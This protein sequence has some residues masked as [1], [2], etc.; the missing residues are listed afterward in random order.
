[1]KF[2]FRSRRSTLRILC[3]ADFNVQILWQV[4]CPTDLDVERAAVPA[5]PAPAP[6]RFTVLSPRSFGVKAGTPTRAPLPDSFLAW[7]SPKAF[8]P[9]WANDCVLNIV[10]T[11]LNNV[12][13]GPLFSN[14][15][16][17]ALKG[18]TG[19][20]ERV[21]WFGFDTNVVETISS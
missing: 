6:L 5:P 17:L 12:K 1:M 11:R 3:W 2:R 14:F 8:A 7:W 4:Q 20:P 13:H 18:M 15:C 10:E 9:Q 19:P 16:T 21:L